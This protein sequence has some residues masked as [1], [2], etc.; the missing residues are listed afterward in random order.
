MIVIQLV[1]RVD[2][3]PSI[4]DG[5]YVVNYN[6]SSIGMGGGEAFLQTTRHL[7][8]ARVF[9]DFVDA[10]NYWKQIDQRNPVRYD[11]KP[12]RPLTIFNI[13]L[14]NVVSESQE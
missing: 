9:K 6:P 2:G 10:T 7:K 13:Q 12:N 5:T 14:I 4:Y 1:E 3:L 11:G 8:E